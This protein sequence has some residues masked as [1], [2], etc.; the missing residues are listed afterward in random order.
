MRCLPFAVAA[1]LTLA[2]GACEPSPLSTDV[3]APRP[4]FQP[5]TGTGLVLSSVTGLSLPLIGRV[6]EVTVEQAVITNFELIENTVGAIVGLEVAGVLQ[7]TGGV[8][9]SDVITEDFTTTA[10]VT[11]SGP[12]Q[13]DIVNID[14][15]GIGIDALGLASVDLPA[16]SVNPQA[17][18]AVGPLLCS[19]GSLLS[20]PIELATDLIRQVVDSINQLI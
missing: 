12:G 13:C 9:G 17:S 10:R 4:S 6:G 16:A 5:S 14:L 7:L 1:L 8:L 11:S 3:T 18:G 19:L 2:A 20:G 15:G